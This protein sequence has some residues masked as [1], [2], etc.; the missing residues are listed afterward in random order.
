MITIKKYSNRRLYDTDQSRYITLEELAER[1]R[2]GSDVR[3]IDAS[4]N[5]DLTQATLVQI[6]LES[7]GAARLLPPSLLVAMIRMGDDALADFL[8]RWMD[9]ALQMYGAARQQAQHV[10][11]PFWGGGNPFGP[12]F[13]GRSPWSGGPY[14]G[15]GGG[16]GGGTGGWPAGNWGGGPAAGGPAGNW[17]QPPWTPGTAGPAGP[18]P[19]GGPM[20]AAEP[21]ADAEPPAASG[22]PETFAGV[23]APPVVDDQLAALRRELAELRETL[24]GVTGTDKDSD[25]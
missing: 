12:L 19:A 10:A 4:T 14:G 1:I 24:S 2:T 7:R 3:V 16:G 13:G 6:V 9:W 17:P 21:P 8:G 15:G 20:P 23:G 18:G 25:S 22:G 5:R 11:T